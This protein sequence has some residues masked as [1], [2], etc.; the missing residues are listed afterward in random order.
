VRHF[1][2][3]KRSVSCFFSY[4]SVESSLHFSGAELARPHPPLLPPGLRVQD[5]VCGLSKTQASPLFFFLLE[6]GPGLL[7]SVLVRSDAVPATPSLVFM[8][9]RKLRFRE[10][11]SVFSWP[12][13]HIAGSSSISVGRRAFLPLTDLRASAYGAASLPLCGHPAR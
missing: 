3:P 6:D 11:P 13:F 12:F 5:G 10:R 7:L 4:L 9:L 8:Q 1:P 2:S